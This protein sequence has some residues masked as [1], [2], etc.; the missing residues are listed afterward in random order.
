MAQQVEVSG[1]E[2]IVTFNV[3]RLAIGTYALQVIV[4]TKQTY[5]LIVKQ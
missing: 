2:Q 1:G 5:Q 4:G 3:S